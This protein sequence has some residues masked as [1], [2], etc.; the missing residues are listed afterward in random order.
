M[1]DLHEAT[2][3][4]LLEEAYRDGRRARRGTRTV[5]D[6]PISGTGEPARMARRAWYRGWNDE[7]D[8]TIDVLSDDD[9]SAKVNEWNDE[10]NRSRPEGGNGCP[11]RAFGGARRPR[12]GRI[13][14]Q[15]AQTEQRGNDGK[16]TP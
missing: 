6:C 4:A 11:Q 12:P 13:F 5:Q 16:D 15:K 8:R 1:T 10:T 3:D 7:C 14:L 2:F 9:V